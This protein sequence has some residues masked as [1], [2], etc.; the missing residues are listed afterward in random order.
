MLR[1]PLT[2]S[3]SRA[4]RLLAFLTCL[5]ALGFVA[6]SALPVPSSDARSTKIIELGGRN[7]NTFSPNCGRDFSRDC[8]IEGKVTAFQALSARYTGRNFVVP[9][10]G[11]LIA[12]SIKLAQPTRVD[13]GDHGAQL[14]FA[15]GIF[16]APSRAGIAILRQVERDKPGPRFRLVRRSPVQTLNPYFGTRVTFALDRPLNVFKGNI[17]ALTIPTWAPARWKPRVCNGTVYGDLDPERCS[18]ARSQYTW[19]GSR[20]PRQNTC[21]LGTN[22]VGEPNEQLATTRPQNGINSIRRY[23]C[24]YGGNV[25]LYSAHIVGR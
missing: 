24:Y 12:W 6:L 25:L 20:V 8:T 16:G 7:L 10:N 9:F 1:S 2:P 11:K 15:N 17:V 14:P 19:R 4:A 3:G 23:G 21:A 13:V 5:A 22:D 18:R